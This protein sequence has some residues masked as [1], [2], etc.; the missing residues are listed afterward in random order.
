[1]SATDGKLEL[2][3]HVPIRLGRGE[4]NREVRGQRIGRIQREREALFLAT[5][6]RIRGVLVGLIAP[7]LPPC[8][9][10]FTRAAPGRGLDPEENLPGSLKAVKDELAK[11]LGV[12]DRDPRLTWRYQ[13]ERGDWG[14]WVHIAAQLPGPVVVAPRASRSATREKHS[15]GRKKRPD[16]TDAL[17]G[18]AVRRKRA[19]APWPAAVKGALSVPAGRGAAASMDQ[20]LAAMAKPAFIAPRGSP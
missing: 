6:G 18:E 9:V 5:L 11:L 1:L 17:L 3:F 14:L 8:T 20:Q 19:G 12:D 10:T 4:N 7:G 13:Q 15:R 16:L 2:R